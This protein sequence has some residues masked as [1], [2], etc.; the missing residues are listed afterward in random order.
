MAQLPRSSMVEVAKFSNHRIL[1]HILPKSSSAGSAYIFREFYDLFTAT[2]YD[3]VF[4][5]G[6]YQFPESKT[7]D[8]LFASVK[9]TKLMEIIVQFIPR[10]SDFLRSGLIAFM[11]SRI[12]FWTSIL[13]FV[14]LP[15]MIALFAGIVSIFLGIPLLVWP[16][17]QLVVAPVAAIAMLAA[18]L[19]YQA[20]NTFLLQQY[21][22]SAT[23]ILDEGYLPGFDERKS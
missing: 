21:P 11:A 10:K 22:Y 4:H 20:R 3:H 6:F 7:L 19:F 14:I 9:G 12:I 13:F 15:W 16:I 8:F 2:R 18:G 23:E 5:F 17:T 1:L